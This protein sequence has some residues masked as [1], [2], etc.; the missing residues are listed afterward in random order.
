MFAE[1][2][3]KKNYSKYARKKIC[4]KNLTICIQLIIFLF[5]SLIKNR[6]K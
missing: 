2:F 4:D 6:I 1:N 3:S 5:Y